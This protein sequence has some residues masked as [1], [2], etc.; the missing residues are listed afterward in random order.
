MIGCLKSAAG[1]SFL[2]LPDPALNGWAHALQVVGVIGACGT[3]IV[4]YDAVRCWADRERWW[5]S[6]C[7]AVAL[8]IA[9]LAH[10]GF[11]LLWHLF[12]FSMG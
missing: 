5:F 9:C 6:K 2:K 3:L 10:V 8:S 1:L 12:D 4:L 7:H 11:A